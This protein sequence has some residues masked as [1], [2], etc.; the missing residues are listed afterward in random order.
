MVV[1]NSLDSAAVL[2]HAT[3]YRYGLVSLW[4]IQFDVKYDKISL[5]H[6]KYLLKWNLNW[7]GSL[8]FNK[9]WISI[10]NIGTAAPIFVD[11]LRKCHDEF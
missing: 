10:Y 1:E 11:P 3:D 2:L 4:I 6:P 5:F 7:N 9:C 8:R